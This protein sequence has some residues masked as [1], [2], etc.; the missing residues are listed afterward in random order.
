MTKLKQGAQLV[1]QGIKTMF[2]YHAVL[3]KNRRTPPKSITKSED[4]HL[5]KTSR[6]KL[7]STARDNRRN[8]ALLAWM[9]R[10]HIDYVATF[11]FQSNSGD[12][13]FDREMESIMSWF[14]R[15]ENFDIAGRHGLSEFLRLVEGHRVVDGDIGV[16]LTRNGKLQGIEGDRIA[17][18]TKGAMPQLQGENVNDDL[19]THGVIADQYGGA[20]WYVVCDR[21]GENLVFNRLVPARDMQMVGYWDRFDQVRGVSPLASALNAIT[22][23]YEVVQYQNI[24]QKMGAMLGVAIMSDKVESSDPWG[25]IDADTGDSPTGSTTKYDFDLRPGL[26]LELQAGDKIDTIESKNP[27]M[28][29]QS[30][31][32]FLIHVAMLSLDIPFTFF[33]SRKSSYSA[34][35]QDLLAYYE[36]VQRKRVQLVQLLDRITA[37]KMARWVSEGLITLP[38]GQSLRDLKWKWL[39]P[40]LPWIDPLKEINAYS[41]AVQNGFSSRQRIAGLMGGDFW[42]TLDQLADEEKALVDSGVTVQLAQPGAIVTRDE[43][44]DNPAEQQGI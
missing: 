10:K 29:F 19:L 25:G 5:D 13:V 2:G 34:Q 27:S 30:Y 43:E 12:R 42:D 32:E 3:D 16:L 31:N 44:P 4:K 26:K 20:R 15:P 41:V 18:P 36:S 7:I 23:F 40:A 28:E 22:D 37:W 39:P 11:N 33:D 1:A 6:K 9:I 17:K 8:Q 24:K 14:A 38:G 21:D 35:R